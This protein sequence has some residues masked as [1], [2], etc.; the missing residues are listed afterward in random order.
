MDI[1]TAEMIVS[2]LALYFAAGLIFAVI[3]VTI[4]IGRVDPNAKGAKL[5]VRLLLIPGSVALWPVLLYH[6]I[7][8]GIPAREGKA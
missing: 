3:F 8:G 6:W 7:R 1:Q 2:A 5:S 4:G